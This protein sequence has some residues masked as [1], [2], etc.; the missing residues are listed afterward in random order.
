MNIEFK[1]SPVFAAIWKAINKKK[2]DNPSVHYYKLIVE[3]GGSRSTKTWSNFQALFLFCFENIF[4]KER[5]G[6]K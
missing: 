2:P 4:M 3:E 1:S 6:K 5:I